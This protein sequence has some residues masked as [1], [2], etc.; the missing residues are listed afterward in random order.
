VRAWV[1]NLFDKDY[2]TRGFFFGN[3]PAKGYVDERFI[4]F[5]EPRVAGVTVSY[6]Y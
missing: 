5:G 3:N 4:Q 1:R 2:A 6:D